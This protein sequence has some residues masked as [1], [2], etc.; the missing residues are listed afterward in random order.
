MLFGLHPECGDA[1]APVII[2]GDFIIEDGGALVRGRA[3][4]GLHTLNDARWAVEEAVAGVSRLQTLRRSHEP[5]D[6]V[7]GR[8]AGDGRG[9]PRVQGHGV[10]YLPDAGGHLRPVE[11]QHG[12]VGELHGAGVHLFLA[13]PLGPAVLEPHLDIEEQRMRGTDAAMLTGNA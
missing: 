10:G 4:H 7:H 6:G 12:R 13:S 5:R 8:G 11:G 9:E 3:D 1:G 2:H